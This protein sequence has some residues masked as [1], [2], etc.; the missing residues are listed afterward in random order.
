MKLKEAVYENCK[1]CGV[2]KATISEESY[3]C[4][5][6]STPIDDLFKKQRGNS[7]YHE[8]LEATVF[9][10]DESKKET[11]RLQFCSWKCVFQKLRKMKN[12]RF[13]SL[14]MPTYDLKTKGMRPQDLYS[15]IRAH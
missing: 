15:L 1:E 13:I 8:F 6:C 12:V 3:G 10:K 7:E 4:D 9:F 5:G 14:P 2:R 11:T